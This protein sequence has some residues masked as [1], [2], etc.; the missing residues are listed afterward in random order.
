[1]NLDLIHERTGWKQPVKVSHSIKKRTWTITSTTNRHSATTIT[2]FEEETA[3]FFQ[4]LRTT[5]WCVLPS[6]WVS[7]LEQLKAKKADTGW[8]PKS[9]YSHESSMSSRERDP[10][11]PQFYIPIPEIE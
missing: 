9:T 1:M 2:L 7:L 5:G 10:S 8:F 6:Y 11:A 4:Q 3:T